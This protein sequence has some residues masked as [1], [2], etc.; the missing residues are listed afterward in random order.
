MPPT[1]LFVSFL[2]P[3]FLGSVQSNRCVLEAR[4]LRDNLALAARP[5]AAPLCSN[6]ALR[7]SLLFPNRFCLVWN[8]GKRIGTAFS[9]VV[10]FW[11][12]AE[13]C[14]NSLLCLCAVRCSPPTSSRPRSFGCGA[15]S[16]STTS[17][18]PCTSASGSKLPSIIWATIRCYSAAAPGLGVVL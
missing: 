4:R 7:Y 18:A 17:S 9:C 14:A 11:L 8:Q 6:H 16:T 13:T 3:R 1:R 5:S 10:G 15:W 12:F 2:P